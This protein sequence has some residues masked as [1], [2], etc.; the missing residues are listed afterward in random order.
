MILDYKIW[1]VGPIYDNSA[2]LSTTLCIHNAKKEKAHH[3][4]V[5]ERMHAIWKQVNSFN[6]NDLIRVFYTWVEELPF[7]NRNI[8]WYVYVLVYRYQSTYTECFRK[9]T[10]YW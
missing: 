1:S 9:C 5:E 6:S 3:D 10:S 2:S 8:Q 4:M 7:E